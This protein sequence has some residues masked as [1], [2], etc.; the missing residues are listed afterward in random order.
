MGFVSGGLICGILVAVVMHRYRGGRDAAGHGLPM[1][2]KTKLVKP[3][4]KPGKT[5][6]HNEAEMTARNAMTTL[7]PLG[8]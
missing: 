7:N 4:K 5:K 6:A 2:I 1:E 8:I 3:P